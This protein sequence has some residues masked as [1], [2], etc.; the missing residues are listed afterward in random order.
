VTV[1]PGHEGVVAMATL[2][3]AGAADF[4]AELTPLIGEAVRLATGMVLNAVEAE[5]VVQDACLRAWHRRGNR[6]V[7]TDLRP[8]FLA[9][10]ANQCRELRR[11]RWRRVLRFAAVPTNAGSD[12][13]DPVAAVDLSRAVGAL[14]YRR[15]L[16]VVLRYYL[17]LPFEDAASVMGCSVDA[18]KALVRRGTFDLERALRDEE[19]RQ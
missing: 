11:G 14:P 5:D 2:D 10:V 16:A 8:W 18:V 7:G 4:E 3:D 12:V 6:R 1:L 13:R 15:R 17:D 9:I 19:V